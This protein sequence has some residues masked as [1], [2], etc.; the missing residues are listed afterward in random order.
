M[1]IR[2][3]SCDPLH[4]Q[5]HPSA[6]VEPWVTLGKNVVIHPYAVVGRLPDNSAAL[7]R[8]SDAQSFLSIGDNTIIG[9]H[10]VIYGGSTIGSDC[11]IGD[12]ASVREG[13]EIGNRCVIG[14]GASVSY[15]V[16]MGNDC[17]VQNRT[18]ITDGS[19]IGD[20]CFFG[21]N[22]VMFSDR[23][24]D[25]DNYAHHGSKGPRFGKKVLIGSGSV[26]MA[27]IDIGDHAVIGAGALVVKSVPHN[28]M[29][30]GY[31]AMIRGENSQ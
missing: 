13:T 30:L 16:T 19:V 18:H 14:I 31:P 24:I 22:V 12:Y 25:L 29:V 17:R 6:V 28:A 1:E 11:L 3:G 26:I 15:D 10:A 2:R 5:Q 23:R 7:A 8:K 21:V 27:D 9:A 20:E 4:F